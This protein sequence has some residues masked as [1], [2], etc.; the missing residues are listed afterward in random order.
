MFSVFVYEKWEKYPIYGSKIFLK[1][2]LIIIGRIRSQKALWQDFN[3]FMYDYTIHRRRKHFCPYCLHAFSTAELLKS[4]FNFCFKINDKQRIRMPQK[5]KYVIL[6]NYE[7][8][9]V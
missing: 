1:D 3:T 8:K 6:K 5:G 9:N 4:Q 7:R 2:I